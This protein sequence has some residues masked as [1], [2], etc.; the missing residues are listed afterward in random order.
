MFKKKDARILFIFFSSMD[1]HGKGT[2]NSRDG[3]EKPGKARKGQEKPRTVCVT[4][5][6][7][8]GA[9][10]TLETDTSSGAG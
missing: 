3:Q 9:G 2:Q 5:R 1:A 4:A 8:G 10:L 7:L 6:V